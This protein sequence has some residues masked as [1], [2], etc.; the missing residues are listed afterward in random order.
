MADDNEGSK[1]RRK[2]DSL[3]FFTEL[4]RLATDPKGPRFSLILMSGDHLVVE[5]SGQLAVLRLMYVYYPARGGSVM[6]PFP[7]ICAVEILD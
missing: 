5:Q 6:I 2:K 3:N 7:N 1:K 4:D